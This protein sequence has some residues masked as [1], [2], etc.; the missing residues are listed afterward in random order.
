MRFATVLVHHSEAHA[1]VVAALRGNLPVQDC[2]KCGDLKR[3][4]SA[5][6]SAIVIAE[7]RDR[8]GNATWPV[9][10]ELTRGFSGLPILGYCTSRA[11]L[12]A[13]VA[14]LARAGVHDIVFL[15]IDDTTNSLRARL[16][17]ARSVGNA[18]WALRHLAPLLS[19][20][21]E[22][23]VRYALVNASREVKV[24]ELAA[25]LGVH[26][27]T[28]VNRCNAS[29]APPPGN[30]VSWCRVLLAARVLEDKGRP[31]EHIAYELGFPSAGALRGM[32]KR[33]VRL[34]LQELRAAGGSSFVLSKF[35]VALKTR[36]LDSERLDGPIRTSNSRGGPRLLSFA[37]DV[38]SPR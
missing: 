12:S 30:I 5:A 20:I 10:T 6:G 29:G 16:A 32:I 24:E 25:V 17:R 8:C 21:I 3:I 11:S 9:L 2:E 19:P 28:L 35:S 15:G 23:L 14:D 22:P 18:E 31:V 26:R 34:T 1:R 36:T 38:E 33:Y 13:D 27:K 7:P 4:S 37:S